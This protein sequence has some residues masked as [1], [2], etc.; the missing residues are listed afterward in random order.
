MDGDKRI[1][2]KELITDAIDPMVERANNNGNLLFRFITP[3]D[4]QES[5]RLA[6]NE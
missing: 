4:E 2:N 5:Q 3:S 1:S 6:R